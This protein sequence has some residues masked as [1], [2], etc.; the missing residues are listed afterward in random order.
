[1]ANISNSLF[2]NFWVIWLSLFFS[3]RYSMHFWWCLSIAELLLL[4]TIL[5]QDIHC[6]CHVFPNNI[7]YFILYHPSTKVWLIASPK[8]FFNLV[9]RHLIQL[10]CLEAFT[11]ICKGKLLLFQKYGK[12]NSFS[13][14]ESYQ[15]THRKE[16]TK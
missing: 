9:D 13:Q 7:L 11:K 2:N 6:I 4:E 5:I 12:H 16:G 14:L 3:W 15:G 8:V 1:M 10:S